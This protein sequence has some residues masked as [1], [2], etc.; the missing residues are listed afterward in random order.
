[1]C[2]EYEAWGWQR[3]A[4]RKKMKNVVEPKS[5]DVTMP[6]HKPAEPARTGVAV[7]EDEKELVPAE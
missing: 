4:T 6:E 5:R 3:E 1:M 7:R 2:H